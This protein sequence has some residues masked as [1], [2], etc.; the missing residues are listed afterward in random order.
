L[1]DGT[2]APAVGPVDIV[3]EQDRIERIQGVGYLD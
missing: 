3:I 2:G 1:I